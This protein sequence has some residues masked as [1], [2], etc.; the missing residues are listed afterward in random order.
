[1]TS[2]RR[3][4]LAQAPRDCHGTGNL[5]WEE[6]CRLAGDLPEVLPTVDVALAGALGA[7]LAAP[8]SALVSV[9][10]CDVSAMDGYAVAGD[11]PWTV[12]GRVLAGAAPSADSLNAGECLEVATGAPVPSGS[13]AVLPY[14][15]ASRDHDVVRGQ[16]GAPGRHIRRE[17]EACPAGT[18]LVPRGRLVT[19]VVTGLA[20][21]VGH[22][23]L[24]VIRPP[25]VRAVLTGD[26]VVGRGLPGP[27][28]VRD[29][30][31]PMLP[32]IVADAG[33]RLVEMQAVSDEP[34]RLAD[35]LREDDTDVVAVCGASSA[36]P[37]DHL[38]TILARLGAKV[39]VPG[40]ACRPGHPQ[41]LAR[42]TDGRWV[43]GLP[44]NPFAALAGALTLL[45]PLLAKCAGRGPVRNPSARIEGEVR[46]H[47]TDTR[48]VAVAWSGSSA[49]PVGH[50]RP[51]ALW[52]A[53]I[54]DALAVVPPGWAGGPVELLPLPT[55]HPQH[56]S[57][58][59]DGGFSP[60]Q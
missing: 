20:A 22:D 27:G 15:E 25:R 51:A 54:A 45:A 43:V 28:R 13:E 16:A 55:G 7:T 37:A 2:P 10:G 19:P 17:G 8:L 42:M 47:P 1:M 44:G 39:L 46:P 40:V 9:P 4:Q 6:A 33:G 59:A 58:D 23:T 11:G 12:V 14:E 32:G 38:H 5:P 31:G 30:V 57:H 3:E 56:S 60:R 29:A 49:R 36:G 24:A 41:S 34:D 18:T 35:L 26:E 50:D 52:G 21:S 48:L 53:A